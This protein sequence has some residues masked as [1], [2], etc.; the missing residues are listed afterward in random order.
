M[1]GWQRQSPEGRRREID[2]AQ[3]SL[4][5]G[6]GWEALR[7]G[8]RWREPGAGGNM[9]KVSPDLPARAGGLSTLGGHWL[10]ECRKLPTYLWLKVWLTFY[11]FKVKT[12]GYTQAICVY[13]K[14]PFFHLPDGQEGALW[15]TRAYST[16]PP[17][18]ASSLPAGWAWLHTPPSRDN[19]NPFKGLTQVFWGISPSPGNPG[20]GGCI[21]AISLFR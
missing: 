13:Q 17:N 7:R 3:A 19:Q 9:R 1:P 11:P 8:V 16:S 5:A 21:W 12:Q 4:R 6:S 2:S 10:S 18:L 20:D 15:R 14:G